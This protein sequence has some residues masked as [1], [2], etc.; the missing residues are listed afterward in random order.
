MQHDEHAASASTTP[1]TNTNGFALLLIAAVGVFLVL[2][3][4]NF[5]KDGSKE[6]EHYRLKTEAHAPEH[7]ASH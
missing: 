4:W 5:W 3:C 2:F 7:K 1:E 6:K